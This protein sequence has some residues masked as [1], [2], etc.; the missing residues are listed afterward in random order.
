[1]SRAAD[2]VVMMT[3]ESNIPKYLY[4]LPPPSRLVSV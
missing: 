2:L 4:V 1:M 3:Q